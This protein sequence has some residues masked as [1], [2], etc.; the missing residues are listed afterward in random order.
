MGEIRHMFSK[1]VMLIYTLMLVCH[2][3]LSEKNT[4]SE[5]KLI[6]FSFPENFRRKSILMQSGNVS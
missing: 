2:Y 1:E 3:N 4:K 5:S 6:C